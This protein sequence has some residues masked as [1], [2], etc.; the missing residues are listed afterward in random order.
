MNNPHDAIEQDAPTV[1]SEAE[2]VRPNDQMSEADD[3][4]EMLSD[5]DSADAPEDDD[6]RAGAI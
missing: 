2:L 4:D 3:S 1:V 5:D 6:D